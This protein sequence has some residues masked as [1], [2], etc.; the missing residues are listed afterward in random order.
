MYVIINIS[1]KQ[2]KAFEGTKIRVPKQNGEVG[3]SLT[4]DEVLLLS[5]DNSTQ[6]GDPYVKGSSV[7]ATILDQG[8][9]KKIIVYKKKRRK[10]Y[11]RKNGHRQFYT[12]IEIKK[13]NASKS[14][15]N[16]TSSK[17]LEPVSNDAKTEEE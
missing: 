2:F 1:G 17:N 11:Q 12:E 15:M 7:T 14:K 13:I 3:S 5:N 4:F 16:T 9:D 10:G 8:R 6:I